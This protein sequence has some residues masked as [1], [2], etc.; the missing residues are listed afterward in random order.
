MSILIEG[1]YKKTYLFVSQYTSY[2]KYSTQ[3]HLTGFTFVLNE[4]K[5]NFFRQNDFAD[6]G[7]TDDDVM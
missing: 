1:Q 3:T 6:V 4:Q 7:T 5:E 2:W